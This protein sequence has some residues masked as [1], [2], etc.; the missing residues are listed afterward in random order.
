[1]QI[2]IRARC[3]RG[4]TGYIPV[5][6]AKELNLISAKTPKGICHKE[7]TDHQDTGGKYDNQP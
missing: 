1:M 4:R 5:T 7:Y 6:P 3:L 2:Q